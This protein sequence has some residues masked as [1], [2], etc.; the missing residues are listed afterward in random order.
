MHALT[1]LTIIELKLFLRDPAAAFFTLAFP[2][3]LL[4]LNGTGRDN[5]PIDDLGGHGVIDVIVPMLTVVVLAM[6]AFTC[7]PAVLAAYRERRILRR[8]AATPLPAG[9]VLA[10]Q[11]LVNLLVGT[12]AL[13]GLL[14]VGVL[15]YDLA[16][17]K[18]LAATLGVFLLGGLALFALG[19]LLA[20]VAPTAR[21]AS[22]AGYAIFFPLLFLSGTMQPREEMPESLRRIGDFLPVSPVVRS[23]RGA[24]VGETPSTLTF[25]LF[26][27]IIVVAGGVAL[28]LFRWE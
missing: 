24:W 12:A 16:P 6:L 20:A 15:R 28:R 19:F 18:A 8:L 14:V 9:S 3:L 25:A 2:L 13:I 21:F 10:A 5:K 22:A 1:K 27:A 26:A 17:P 23:L 7:L 11:F 4:I